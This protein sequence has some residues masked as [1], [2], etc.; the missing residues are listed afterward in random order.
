M[1]GHVRKQDQL[2]VQ[3]SGSYR[4]ELK[5]QYFQTQNYGK[6]KADAPEPILQVKY[7]LS[8]QCHARLQR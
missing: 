3:S 8:V 5:T 6:G 7:L 4:E 1:V 2:P